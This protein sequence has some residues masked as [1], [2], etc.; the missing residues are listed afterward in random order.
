MVLNPGYIYFQRGRHDNY[1]EVKNSYEYCE[2]II[3]EHSKSFYKAFSLLP[4]EKAN[5]IYAVY[6]F[7]RLCD[8]SIDEY[9]DLNMLLNLESELELFFSG[10]TPDK[11]IW[12]ALNDVTKKYKIK[13]EPFFDLIKGQKMDYNFK[14]FLTQEDL[15][16][17]CY[18]VAG[19]V[20]LMIL[21]ILA[22]KNHSFLRETAINLGKAMQLTNILRD[23]GQDY[24]NGR[25]YLPTELMDKY[26]Y[27]YDDLSK[28][29]INENFV[30]L[31]EYEAKLAEKLYNDSLDLISEFDDD[32]KYPVL[33]AAYIYKEILNEVR[34]NSYDCLNKR[35][36]VSS[37][38]KTQIALEVKKQLK[39]VI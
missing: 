5:A 38:R 35:N 16:E 39:M 3:K 11:P 17:Y 2:D 8:D 34:K 6:G 14:H 29:I 32:S 37:L 23:I 36:V 28:K 19:T 33:T 31:W 21:P 4:E 30:N 27:S 20:G 9:N 15:M 18:Y 26:N 13:K 22:T 1:M 24:D 12:I 10:I 7:C 25:V